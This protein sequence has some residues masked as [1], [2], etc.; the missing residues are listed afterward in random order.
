MPDQTKLAITNCA[1]RGS[2]ISKAFRA[3]QHR[4]LLWYYRR[5]SSTIL[6][7]PSNLIGPSAIQLI[8]NYDD[9]DH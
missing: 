8:S 3:I 2:A 6:I 4:S 7:T 9:P 5:C 1:S